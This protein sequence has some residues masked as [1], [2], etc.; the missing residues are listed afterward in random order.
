MGRGAQ[1]PRV[2]D[3]KRTVASVTC[4]ECG[5]ELKAR[6]QV[7]C[8]PKCSGKRNRLTPQKIMQRF[9][10]RVDKSGECWIWTAGKTVGGYGVFSFG[11]NKQDMAHRWSYKKFVGPIPDGLFID[12]LCR[13]RACVRPSHLE[14]VTNRENILRGTGFSARH[15]A[16]T[17]CSNGHEFTPENT[18]IM[19][20]NGVFRR[21][22]CR[23]CH[24]KRWNAWYAKSRSKQ[25]L[26]ERIAAAEHEA[27]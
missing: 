21:R 13:N 18:K 15:A 26:R 25:S 2:H 14:P 23:I 22:I 9:W 12:H 20:R 7:V 1:V 8:G 27:A 10:E 3:G 24:R 5:A 17:Q 11:K 4:Q 16:K 19:R 6:Q